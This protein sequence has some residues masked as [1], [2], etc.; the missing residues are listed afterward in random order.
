MTS[1]KTTVKTLASWTGNGE[2][3]FAIETRVVRCN[4]K[5]YVVADEFG[6]DRDLR[7]GAYRPHVYL[8][9]D[10]LAARAVE[11][12]ED[13]DGLDESYVHPNPKI[14]VLHHEILSD[15]SVKCLGVIGDLSWTTVL[16]R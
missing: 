1:P 11:L 13:G 5:T 10:H 6:G 7:G 4:G 12:V 2:Y 8:I 3:G 14:G 16:A 9:P 15:E